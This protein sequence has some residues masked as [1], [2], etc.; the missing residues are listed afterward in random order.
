MPEGT[1]RMTDGI[2]LA[3][4]QV[5]VVAFIRTPFG[6]IARTVDGNR[7]QCTQQASCSRLLARPSVVRISTQG[8]PPSSL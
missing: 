8:L 3:K 7:Q 6:A 2:G 1:E 5:L 4:D